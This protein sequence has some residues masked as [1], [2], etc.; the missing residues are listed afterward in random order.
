MQEKDLQADLA[1]FTMSGIDQS[2]GKLP[3][4]KFSVTKYGDNFIQFDSAE[5]QVKIN[6]GIFFPAQHKILNIEDH[7]VKIDNKAFYGSFWKNAAQKQY[8]LFK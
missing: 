8:N 4:K 7:V 2:I 1:V 3:L 6:S 5:I